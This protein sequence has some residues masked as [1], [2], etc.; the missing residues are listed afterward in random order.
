MLLGLSLPHR[1]LDPLDVGEIIHTARRAEETGFDD[2]WVTNNPLDRAAYCAD[3]FG[4]LNFVAAQTDRVGLG[5]GVVILPAY[6]PIHVA[7]QAASLDWLSDGRAI[8]GLGL[9]RRAELA[10]FG[11]SSDQLVRRFEEQV[12]IIKRLWSEPS[13]THA[14]EVYDLHDAGM[15]L[16]PRRRPHP[17]LWFGGHHPNAVRRAVRLGDGWMAAGGAGDEHFVDGVRQVREVLDHEGRDPNSFTLSKRV[18][19]SVDDD[20]ATARNEVRRWYGEAYGD[21]DRAEGSAAYGTVEQVRDR[22]EEIGAI[23]ADHLLLNPVTRYREHADVVADV[24]PR[25]WRS[26]PPSSETSRAT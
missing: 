10:H 18:F 9:G 4:L 15:R 25:A 14:G 3:S 5:V 7:Q 22:L 6:H 2:V 13:V 24:V 23:G 8:V 26:A 11:V 1:S 17:P 21:P 19:I 20:P 16:R 12:A